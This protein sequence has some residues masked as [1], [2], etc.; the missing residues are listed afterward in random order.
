MSALNFSSVNPNDPWLPAIQWF[1]DSFLQK[2]NI[3]ECPVNEELEKTIPKNLRPY[4][5]LTDNNGSVTGFNVS[6]YEFWI[7]LQLRKRF[8]KGELYLE[9]SAKHRFFDDELVSLDKKESILK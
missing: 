3:T 8:G 7:Y 9:D 2:K 5:L 6:H 1:K 4:L